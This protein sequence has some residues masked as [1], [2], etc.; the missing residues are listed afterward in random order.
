M[1]KAYKVTV[2]VL[3]ID[4]AFDAETSGERNVKVINAVNAGLNCLFATAESVE[5]ADIGEWR[6]EHPLN[7]RGA[8]WHKYFEDK[9]GTSD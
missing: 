4:N 7:Y 1:T 3:D 2:L 9:D 5:E 6:D 8:D